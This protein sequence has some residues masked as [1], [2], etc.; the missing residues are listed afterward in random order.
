MANFYIEIIGWQELEP[1][2]IK[3]HICQK[4]KYTVEISGQL[5]FNSNVKAP[6]SYK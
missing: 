2:L 6:I 5:D 4:K 1:S 3:D